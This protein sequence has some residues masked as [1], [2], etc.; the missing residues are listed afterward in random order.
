MTYSTLNNTHAL[1]SDKDKIEDLKFLIKTAND[2]IFHKKSFLKRKSV[3]PELVKEFE[4][5]IEQDNIYID[6]LKAELNSLKSKENVV[7]N[8]IVESAIPKKH[9]NKLCTTLQDWLDKERAKKGFDEEVWVQKAVAKTLAYTKRCKIGCLA[10]NV[11]GGVDSSAVFAVLLRTQYEAPDNHPLNKNYSFTNDKGDRIVKLGKIVCAKQFIAGTK[12]ITERIEEVFRDQAIKYN[13]T[14]EFDSNGNVSKIVSEKLN[15]EVHDLDLT[16][17]YHSLVEKL[18]NIHGPLNQWAKSMYKSYLRTPQIFAL[19]SSNGGIVIG[20][21][22][23][24]EDGYLFYFCKFGDGA[25]DASFLWDLHKSEVFRVAKHLGVSE[26]VLNSPPSADLAPGQTDEEEIGATYDFVELL[27]KYYYEF[28]WL[29]KKYFLHCL[30]KDPEA[31]DQFMREKALVDAI[32]N[33]GLHKEDINPK[34]LKDDLLPKPSYFE[35]FTSFC[36]LSQTSA[37]A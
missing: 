16:D 20:T 21:G 7:D 37:P 30:K 34:L 28:S 2:S 35:R 13:A 19:A 18:E 8:L 11:S 17:D 22:N 24:D 12:D 5:T 32:H 14:R 33:R 26:I 25:V 15:V 27:W 23:R 6:S 9:V 31:Y 10:L 4:T 3:K 29:K 36:E 1:L